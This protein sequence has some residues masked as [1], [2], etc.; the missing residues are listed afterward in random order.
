MTSQF[1]RLFRW[2]VVRGI[3][4]HKLLAALNILSVA[5]GVAVFLAI[6]IANHSANRSF[7]ASIDLVAG[8]ANLEARSAAGL[9]DENLLPKLARAPGVKAATPLVEGYLTLPDYRGEYLQ[10][11]GVDPFTNGPFATFAIETAN[12]QRLDIEAWLRDPGSLALSEEFAR[13]YGLKVGDKLRVA[14]NGRE[15]SLT[16]R[17]LMRLTESPAGSNSR[18]GAMDIAWAQELF[19]RTGNLSSIQLLLEEPARAE[20]MAVEVQKLVPADVNIL[21]PGQRSGQ[22]QRML[23]SFELNLSALSMVS[24]LVGMFLIYNTIA[25]SVVRRRAEVGIL[26]AVGASRVDVLAL[27]L[28]EAL[29]MGIFGVLLGL[30]GGIL[31]SGYLVGAVAKTISSLY[32]LVRIDQFHLTPLLIAA[33]VAF[34]LASVLIAAW[35]PAWE[36]ARMD[37]IR[38][39]NLGTVIEGNI[40]S[41]PRWL[42]VGLGALA[43]AGA[44]S[45]LALSTGPALLGFV[46]ALFVV[47]GFAFAAPV[48]TLAGARLSARAASP[49]A[50]ARLA[51]QN[52]GRSL[53]RNAVTVAALMAAIAMMVGVSVMIFA[54]RRTVEVWINR[55]IVADIF[56]TPASNETVGLAAFTPPEVIAHLRALPAV[57]RLDTFREIGVT[58]RGERISLAVVAGSRR[59]NLVFVGGDNVRKQALIFDPA[60]VVVTESFA[61]RFNLWEGA[62]LPLATPRGFVEFTIGGVYYDYTRDSGVILIGRENFDRYWED[63]RVQSLGLYLKDPATL[64]ATMDEVRAYAGTFGRYL[65]YSNRSIRTRIFEIFDQTFRITYVLRAIAVVVAVVGIFLGLTTLVAEREREIGVLRSIGAS[66][67]QIRAMVLA[68]SGLIGLLAS[69]LGVAAG[70]VL[71]LV[72]TFVI[73]KAFFGWT[74]QLAFPWASLALTPLWIVP[75]ALLAGWIPAVRASRIPIAAAVRSE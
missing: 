9:I 73:N 7:V 54:F 28:G 39:L 20:A 35:F 19:G 33:A 65:V 15:R 16:I 40:V 62:K 50:M 25:A 66:T 1:W 69:L 64:E 49:V 18:V 11:L 14:V 68:E 32:I 4:R 26:R 58:V 8:K 53:H 60:M 27:F 56:I 75:A 12:R 55:T 57:D 70:L 36:G 51:A 61:R 44:A 17:F 45:G 37:P 42:L 5:L 67:L 46:S 48:L 59:D 71:S 30:A 2:H 47:V 52:L 22:V 63:P 31:L 23:A 38:A 13:R 41:P 34:G 74:I 3:A 43:A 29:L 6:Q 10:I 24:L 72:L 21:V